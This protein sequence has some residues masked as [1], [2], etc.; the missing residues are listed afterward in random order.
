MASGR[1][2]TGAYRYRKSRA[3]ILAESDIC[4]LCGHGGAMT[5]DHIITAKHWPKGADG[6]HLPG[7]D[8]VNNLR[9]AHGTAGSRQTG[10]LNRC[11]TCGRLCNQARGV[12]PVGP[13]MRSRDW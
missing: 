7:L 9:P 5:V 6:K 1:S 3:Q 10:N 12:R 2:G 4:W 13:S 8:E 11:D